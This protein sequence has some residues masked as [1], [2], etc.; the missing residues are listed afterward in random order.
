MLS[1]KEQACIEC[2]IRYRE[3]KLLS[4]LRELTVA[5]IIRKSPLRYVFDVDKPRITSA[6][7][8]NEKLLFPFV[9]ALKLFVVLSF[10]LYFLLVFMS[11]FFDK[12]SLKTQIKNVPFQFSCSQSRKKKDLESLWIVNSFE[13]N[14]CSEE[15]RLAV[16]KMWV[17]ALYGDT[18]LNELELDNR[19]KEVKNSQAKIRGS[20]YKIGATVTLTNPV[21]VLVRNLSTELQ[22]YE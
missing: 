14:E 2:I 22:T 12:R 13:H 10:P 21:D 4:Q 8:I 6:K 19:F 3:Q 9:I 15:E 7:T 11:K 16:L 1:K 18:T 20:C 17:L 5:N